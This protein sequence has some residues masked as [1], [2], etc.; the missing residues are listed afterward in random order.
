MWKKILSSVIKILISAFLLWFLFSKIDFSEF[1][2]A[3]YLSNPIFIILALTINTVGTL[4]GVYRW[5]TLL[6]LQKIFVPF[7]T[8]L[9]ISLVSGFFGVF[10]P[11]GFGGDVIRGYDVFRYSK[12]GVQVV[13][14]I[15]V[16]RIFGLLSLLMIGGI[17]L[18]IG[19][20][21]FD[22]KS[23]FIGIITV[24]VFLLL[25]IVLLFNQKVLDSIAPKLVKIPLISKLE[26]KIRQF[27]DSIEIYKGNT[28]T[29]AAVMTISLFMQC[30]GILYYYLISLSLSLEISLLP[31][32]AVMPIVWIAT[33]A[34][35]TVG[36]LGIKEGIFV[37]L[38]STLGVT[39]HHALLLSLLGT[40]LYMPFAMVGAIIFVAR[41]RFNVKKK[42]F[43]EISSMRP[44]TVN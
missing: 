1:T 20:K 4:L 25:L 17:A 33:M 44:E 19:Y 38:L 5:K 34:P 29:L 41:K 11:S 18:I 32:F 40:V 30:T 28:K 3:L 35:F 36:G 26:N 6:N 31:F 13:A 16:E 8:L 39:A 12:Q 27:I 37:L 7:K 10:L 2:Q 15:M 23:I 9:S 21:L 42:N 24:Y 22:E 14:S 43:D